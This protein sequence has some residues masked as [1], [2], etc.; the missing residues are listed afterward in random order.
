M[1]YKSKQLL[2]ELESLLLRQRIEILD[3]TRNLID[4]NPELYTK[5]LEEYLL[6]SHL[7]FSKFIENLDYIQDQLYKES[8]TL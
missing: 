8:E 6:T 3:Y 4:Y 7:E 5:T 2:I 1:N